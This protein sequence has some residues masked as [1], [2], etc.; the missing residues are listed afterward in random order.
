MPA[1]FKLPPRGTVAMRERTRDGVSEG[2]PAAAS[3]EPSPLEVSEQERGERDDVIRDSMAQQAA[4]G[5]RDEGYLTGLSE[6]ANELSAFGDGC[7][8]LYRLLSGQ[9]NFEISFSGPVANEV[10]EQEV[11]RIKPGA[12]K[13][14]VVRRFTVLAPEGCKLR[15]YKNNVGQ[16]N[17]V[18]VFTAAQEGAAEI[19]GTIRLR[20]SEYLVGTVLGAKAAG[21]A[22]VHLEG[23]MVT[24]NPVP[25]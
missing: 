3:V 2:Q 11:G 19:P 4:E 8:K 24:E 6:L 23:D 17:L 16:G 1:G 25:W 22:I 7:L 9:Y 18:E 12:G 21:T 14:L 13:L 20:E 5:G 10:A 15:L